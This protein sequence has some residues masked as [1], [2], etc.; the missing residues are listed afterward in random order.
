MAMKGWASDEGRSSV[1]TRTSVSK[2]FWL[3]N[4]LEKP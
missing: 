4:N 3:Y 2:R 1:A